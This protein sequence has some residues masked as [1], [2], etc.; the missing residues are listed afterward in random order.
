MILHAEIQQHK[1]YST[2]VEYTVFFLVYMFG[3]FDKNQVTVITQTFIW[4]FSYI[5]LTCMPVLCQYQAV[6]YFFDS[7]M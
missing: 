3:I 6:F 4:F 2:F 7:L 1:V 5:L